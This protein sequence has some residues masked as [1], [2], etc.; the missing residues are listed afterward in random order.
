MF[1]LIIAAEGFEGHFL[2]VFFGGGSSISNFPP[3]PPKLG[4]IQL[5]FCHSFLLHFFLMDQP[6]LYID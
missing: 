2:L 5:N 3:K 6:L 4:M 1:L